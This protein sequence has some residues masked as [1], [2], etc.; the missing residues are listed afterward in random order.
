MLN[1]GRAQ[2]SDRSL[3]TL[4]LTCEDSVSRHVSAQMVDILNI[5]VNK[6]LQTIC[7]FHVFL[8]QVSSIH[9]VS[10]FYCVNA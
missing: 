6:L 3:L 8:V 10:A 5:F 7:I 1:C 2:F 4:Q 9:R